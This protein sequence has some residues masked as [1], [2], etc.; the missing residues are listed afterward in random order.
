MDSLVRMAHADAMFNE[1]ETEKMRGM[2]FTRCAI[3]LALAGPDHGAAHVIAARRWGANSP[4]ASLLTK[5]AVGGANLSDWSEL[6]DARLVA[7]EFLEYVRPMTILGRLQ[8]LRKVPANV[9]YVAMSGAA[10]AFWTAQ[11][12]ATPVSRGAFDRATMAPFRL[13]ALLVLSN[14]LLQAESAEAETLVRNDLAR[15]VAHLADQ[16]FIDPSNAGTAGQTPAS[17]TNGAATVTGT[18]DFRDDIEGAIAAFGGS[19]ETASWVLHPRTAV[20]IGL[21]A[22]AAGQ[23]ADLGARGGVLCRLPAVCSESVPY[24]SNGGIIALIDAASI[25][26]VDE[27][28]EVS[29]S[30][31]TMIEMSDDP[32][33]D[34]VT[35]EAASSYPVSLFQTD[36]TA[37]LVSRRLNWSLARADGVV[38]VDGCDYSGT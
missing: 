38:Y 15:A 24:D 12:R 37:L 30:T 17:V 31:A 29:R 3:A 4:V 14:A 23:P 9:P 1:D 18:T 20:Q 16:T 27:G 2:S 7:A 32:S 13:A 35:L 33:G 28:V 10:T 25:C 5:A 34:S 21:R 11:G 36:S 8:G 22:G 19:L 26:L 6:A